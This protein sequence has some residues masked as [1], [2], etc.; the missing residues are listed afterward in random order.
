MDNNRFLALLSS[1]ADWHYEK[2]PEGHSEIVIDRFKSDNTLCEDCG[3]VGAYHKVV[4]HRLFDNSYPYWR[5]RC[6]LCK[7]IQNPDTDEFD[8]TYADWISFINTPKK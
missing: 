6:N 2:T 5:R 8:M 3:C 1:V 4:E 7:M